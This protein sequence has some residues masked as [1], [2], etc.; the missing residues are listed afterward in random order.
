[1]PTRTYMVVDPRRDH[2]IRVPRPDLTVKIGTR[3]ACQA[4][5]TKENE[6]PQWA[7]DKVV[8]WY[9]PKRREN[10][11]F[12]EAFHAAYTNQPSAESLLLN[13]AKPPVADKAKQVGGIVRAT[14]IALLARFGT[15]EA[16]PALEASLKDSDPL[17]R[18]AAIG[19]FDIGGP[20]DED[21]RRQLKQLI[22]PLLS[23][24]VRL[25][26]TEAV[27]ILSRVPQ[28]TLTETERERFAA[29]FE[30]L[31]EGMKAT[32]DDAGPH[33][34]LGMMYFNLGYT[35][36]A[37]EQYQWAI[38][39]QRNMLQAGQSR[40]QLAAI[41]HDL[42]HNVKAEALYR[43]VIALEPRYAPAHYELGLL[44]A[45]DESRM[46][47][48]AEQLAEA[49]KLE[50]DNARM[51]YNLG[52]A[53]QKSGRPGDAE[54]ELYKAWQLQPASTE[55]LYALTILYAQEQDWQN[56]LACAEQLAKLDPQHRR[57]YQQLL[58]QSQ[59]SQQ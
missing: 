10:P 6:T 32:D 45:E 47:E 40:M 28:A 43:E 48:A 44:F 25:V 30:E 42:K 5:H 27:K 39:L 51:R 16:R 55:F 53:L 13:V 8:E 49:S 41:E 58:R 7:A 20:L 35:D 12:G 56:A 37:V 46:K 23:D 26:R 31:R 57:L 59:Q 2:S 50:P 33:M 3:N 1:M 54:V 11:Q 36:K 22:W 34:I 52:L 14:A 4:C 19:A 24:P 38:K 18:A 21:Q 17:V 29:V 9:G 15:A